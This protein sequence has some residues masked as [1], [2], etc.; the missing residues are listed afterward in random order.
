MNIYNSDIEAEND[1]EDG[2]PYYEYEGW[3][4]HLMI[5]YHE[6]EDWTHT[7]KYA[8]PYVLKAITLET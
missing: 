6:W 1:V 4:L 3:G 8:I 5:M 7:Q 2:F